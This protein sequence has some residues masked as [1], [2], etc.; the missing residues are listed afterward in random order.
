[1]VCVCTNLQPAPDC[2]TG[3]SFST[4]PVPGAT[5]TTTEELNATGVATKT[6]QGT[7]L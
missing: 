1:M 4:V 6:N 3:L 5:K 7:V 2:Y